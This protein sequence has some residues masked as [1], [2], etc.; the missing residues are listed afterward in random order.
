MM[1]MEDETV[2][3]IQVQGRNLI[4]M[5]LPVTFHRRRMQTTN[6]LI[7]RMILIIG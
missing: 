7:L 6:Q 4:N 5:M 3:Q 1:Y 2:L